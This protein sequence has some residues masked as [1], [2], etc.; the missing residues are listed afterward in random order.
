MQTAR[1]QPRVV[2]V[3][4]VG[5]EGTSVGTCSLELWSVRGT[6]QKLLF[7]GSYTMLLYLSMYLKPVR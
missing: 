2:D 4:A 1:A 5:F 6:L 3:G 7:L